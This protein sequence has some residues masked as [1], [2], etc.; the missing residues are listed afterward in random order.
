MGGGDKKHEV[1]SVFIF[2]FPL[3]ER[4]WMPG[5]GIQARH[6]S[7]LLGGGIILYTKDVVFAAVCRRQLQCE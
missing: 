2:I 4:S 1:P 7:P 5:V 3:G 6:E